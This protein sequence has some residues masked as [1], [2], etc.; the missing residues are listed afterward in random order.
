MIELN[1]FVYE[2]FI[3]R[4]LQTKKFE[5]KIVVVDWCTA[6][7]VFLEVKSFQV[8]MSQGLLNRDSLFRVKNEHLLYQINCLLIGTPK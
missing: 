7:F 3:L 2:L 1:F 6:W 8:G 4:N 5:V